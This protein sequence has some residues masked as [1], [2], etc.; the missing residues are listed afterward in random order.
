[1]N[2][3]FSHASWIWCN[4]NPKE[5]EYGEFV[6]DF[7]F[8]QGKVIL[9][10][11]ADSNYA[12]YINGKLAAW[13]QY[14]DFPYD[15]VYDEVDVTA[16]CKKGENH[17]AIS[18]WYYGN[19][20]LAVYYPGRAGL[21]YTVVCEN[22]VL[23]ASHSGTLSRMSKTYMNHRGR[24]I[25]SELGFGYGYDF[26]QEDGWKER[27]IEDFTSSVQVS[28]DLP[29]RIRPCSK[30]TLNPEVV[31]TFC[32]EIVPNHVLYDLGSEQ[33][34][35]LH[36]SITSPQEQ[37]ITVAYGEHIVDGCVRQIL[38]DRDFSAVFKVRAGENVFLNPFRRF[39]CRYLEVISEHPVEIE[40]IAICPTMYPLEIQ[41]RPMLTEKQNKI[42]D[43]CVET[44]RLCM[45]EHYEDCPWREQALYTMDS[46]NQML[47]SYYAFGEYRFPR[48]NLELI[49]KDRREDG[50]LSICFPMKQDFVI[51]SFSLQYVTECIEYME[52]SGDLE[53]LRE[54][55]PKLE[56][57]IATFTG[58][59]Q[60]G[61]VE[62]YR[63]V[64]YWNFYE[65]GGDLDGTKEPEVDIVV[66]TLLSIAMQHMAV[67]ARAL[68]ISN[69]Y[70][71]QAERLNTHIRRVFWDEEAGVCYNYPGHTTYS[72][73][74]NALAILCGAVS[75]EDG[76]A[77]CRKMLEDGKMAPISLS[78]QCFKYDAW[79]RVD[80][81]YFTPIILEDI[82]RI[83]TPMI[84][85][86][87]TTV[88][89][90]A[91]GEKDFKNA[92]SLC[93]GWSALPVYYYHTLL[94]K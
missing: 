83:Y 30:L 2:K 88:W 12:A 6:D 3:N 78:M 86:G 33:V 18:V 49:S 36:F 29:L 37:D 35:F 62:P 59:M 76:K 20:T 44:L 22:Q 61:L 53:F 92:G 84:E 81:E 25:S 11:S 65:W 28:Q 52:H 41:P 13:G 64:N 8:T 50:L 31:G 68:G 82:E 27:I 24:K 57:I 1:M 71:A 39:G 46:R 54:I 89:E 67:I 90:T 94:S 55:Y 77:L 16:Y 70:M 91:L 74:G 9:R 60:N 58:H 38:E 7:A 72:Q 69:D 26:T 85:F 23:C 32:K 14:A 10:I 40:R 19:D 5:D 93:H 4:D 17:L 34:G 15:K 48:A 73:L 51:P 66:N 80:R 63:G 47:C 42:Y 75:K 45:H 21:L 87:S 79:L 56:S 43:M